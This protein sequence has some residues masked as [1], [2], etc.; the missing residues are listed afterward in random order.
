MA[1]LRL[2]RCQFEL[3]LHSRESPHFY[4][5]KQRRDSSRNLELKEKRGGPGEGAK[6]FPAFSPHPEHRERL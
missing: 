4:R 1:Q 2:E 6:P 5:Q 3:Y